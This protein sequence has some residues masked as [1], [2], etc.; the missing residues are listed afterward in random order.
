M[1]LDDTMDTPELNIEDVTVPDYTEETQ[2]ADLT[3]TIT[4]RRQ[5]YFSVFFE[6]FFPSG[7][8]GDTITVTYEDTDWMQ[9]I[10]SSQEDLLPP[11]SEQT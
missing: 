11:P 3:Y 9:Q 6:V 5:Q 8:D 1:F 7:A 4:V 2:P 10:L